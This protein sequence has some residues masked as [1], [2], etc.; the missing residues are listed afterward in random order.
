VYFESAA[1]T[2]PPISKQRPVQ[3]RVLPLNERLLREL[4]NYW[5]AQRQGEAGHEISWLFLGKKTG[6]SMGRSVGANIY[7]RASGVRRKG[8]HPS[9]APFVCN[10]RCD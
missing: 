4:E 1:L 5:R 9:F 2:V 7:Y 8:Q 3:L 6:E 10:D